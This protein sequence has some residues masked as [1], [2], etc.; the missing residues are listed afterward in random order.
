MG[1][2]CA[3][4]AIQVLHAKLPYVQAIATVGVS[5]WFLVCVLARLA[6]VVAIV[7]S[8]FSTASTAENL[9]AT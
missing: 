2:V 6:L 3:A 9:R 1:C 7:A 8:P 5:A 4:K